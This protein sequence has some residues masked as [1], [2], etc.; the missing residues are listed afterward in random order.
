MF[1]VTG[2]LTI[3]FAVWL[4]FTGKSVTGYTGPGTARSKANRIDTISG[5]GMFSL[6]IAC[7]YIGWTL[8]KKPK[9]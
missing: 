7:F 1:F 6:S 3:A 8:L 4:E 9:E 5:I 2:V